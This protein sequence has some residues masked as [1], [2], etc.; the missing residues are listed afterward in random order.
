MPGSPERSSN[1]GP[2]HGQFTTGVVAANLIGNP[3]WVAMEYVPGRTLAD[4]VHDR[5]PLAIRQVELLALG[6]AEALA[7]STPQGSS[8]ETSNPR[9]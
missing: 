4:A 9:T 3:Q 8:T 1:A 7:Q 6:L 2:V 5:G